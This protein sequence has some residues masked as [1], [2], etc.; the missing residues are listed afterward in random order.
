MNDTFPTSP[1]STASSNC[2]IAR[3]RRSLVLVLHVG[4]VAGLGV[5][6]VLDL[7]VVV[8]LWVFGMSRQVTRQAMQGL[9]RP[10]AGGVRGV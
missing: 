3:L 6:V 2:P 9:G 8:L 1:W 7:V 10:M 5:V 4:F